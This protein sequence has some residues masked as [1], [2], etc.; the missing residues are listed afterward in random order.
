[1]AIAT[2]TQELRNK[3]YETIYVLRS[4]VDAD[5]AEKVQGRVAEVVARENG[6]LV[7]VEAWGRRKL[8]YPVG[9]AWNIEARGLDVGRLFEVRRDAHPLFDGGI[10]DGRVDLQASTD[11][12]RFHVGMSARGARLGALVDNA[13]DEPQLGDPTDVTIRFDGAWRRIGGAIEIPEVHASLAG[14]ALS[15]SLALRDLDTDPVVD[16]ALGIQHLDFAQLLGLPRSTC[17]YADA[18]RTPLRSR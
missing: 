17:V 10:A 14:A 7:K 15:G 8:A 18:W 9:S 13:A 4:D 3:E 1:M 5:T 2:T 12:L 11:A 16:L 6:K